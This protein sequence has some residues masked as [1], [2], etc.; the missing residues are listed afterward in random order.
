M[1]SE[2]AY[3]VIKP[4]LRSCHLSL[5]WGQGSLSLI[6]ILRTANICPPVAEAHIAV[7]QISG[8]GLNRA[9]LSAEATLTNGVPLARVMFSFG[10]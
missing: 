8:L 3:H 5:G 2:E 6:V 9:S 1:V 7:T 4:K 10:C